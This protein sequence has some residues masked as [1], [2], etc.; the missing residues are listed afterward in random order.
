MKPRL[1]YIYV[2]HIKVKSMVKQ[3]S[4]LVKTNVIFK[5]FFPFTCFVLFSFRLL[6][7]VS[8]KWMVYSSN[9]LV[10]KQVPRK[11]MQLRSVLTRYRWCNNY[12]S[13]PSSYVGV[14]LYERST[15]GFRKLNYV[16]VFSVWCQWPF[17]WSKVAYI[18]S[19]LADFPRI[20]F[21]YSVKVPVLNLKMN[22][23]E[24]MVL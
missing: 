12:L 3:K 20:W 10:V 18:L 8:G 24:P 11:K 15:V 19:C 16:I 22:I 2:D 9:Y 5:L 14:V 21:F 1:W 6:Y 7:F 13:I 17:F 4:S 23:V